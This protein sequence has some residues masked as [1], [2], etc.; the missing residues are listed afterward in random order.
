MAEQSS[1]TD[2]QA[3]EI[4][5][6]IACLAERDAEVGATI[7]SEQACSRP[8]VSAGQFQVAASLTGSFAVPATMDMPAIAMP[9]EL[10]LG[11][12]GDDVVFEFSGVIEFAA[13]AMGALRGTDFVFDEDGSRRRIGTKNA[14]VLAMFL[15]PSIVRGSLSWL[16]LIL[17]TFASLEKGLDL[18]FELRDPLAQ[19]GVLRFE[20]SN[21]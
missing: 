17:G 10:R 3:E 14:G 18:M 7:T 5:Q 13:A 20:F 2:G 21:P 9:F 6:Q 15:P 8:N 19:L 11:N 12:V 1:A 16:A 4:V